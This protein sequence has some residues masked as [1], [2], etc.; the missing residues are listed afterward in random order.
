MAE[1]IG[2][3]AGEEGTLELTDGRSESGTMERLS[4]AFLFGLLALSAMLGLVIYLFIRWRNIGEGSV[5]VPPLEMNTEGTAST[6]LEP[7]LGLTSEVVRPSVD[8]MAGE[9]AATSM[10]QDSAH[11][12]HTQPT[13]GE[14]FREIVSTEVSVSNTPGS[15]AVERQDGGRG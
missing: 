12:S 10:G 14:V 7:T 2:R 15:N 9:G 13:Y 1:S 8:K 11:S 4:A 5:A 6:P 3:V